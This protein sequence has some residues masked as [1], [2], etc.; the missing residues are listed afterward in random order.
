MPGV[1][2]GTRHKTPQSAQAVRIAQGYNW[3]YGGSRSAKAHVT[4]VVPPTNE[5]NGFCRF[6]LEIDHASFSGCS[7][8]LYGVGKVKTTQSL[9][10]ERTN[11]TVLRFKGNGLSFNRSK[12]PAVLRKVRTAIGVMRVLY[13]MRCNLAA[14]FKIYFRLHRAIGGDY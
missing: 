12:Y 9:N 10:N 2:I 13:Q 5:L 4:Y 1:G 14:P 7:H 6:N 8:I 3:T 11:T